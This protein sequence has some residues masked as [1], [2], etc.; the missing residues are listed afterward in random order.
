MPRAN[1]FATLE[2]LAMRAHRGH[3]A[4]IY[5]RYD[6]GPILGLPIGGELPGGATLIQVDS[7][8]G[9]AAERILA[10]GESGEVAARLPPPGQLLAAQG[11]KF[12]SVEEERDLLASLL[13]EKG[14]GRH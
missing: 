12:M 10:S 2:R 7:V 8:E 11:P 9:D 4:Q 6:D 3:K 1:R 14:D 13:E 5:L